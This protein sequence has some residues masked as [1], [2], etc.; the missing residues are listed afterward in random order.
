MYIY[1][2]TNNLFT[3][4]SGLDILSSSHLVGV[5][6]SDNAQIIVTKEMNGEIEVTVL[7][8][9][10]NTLA[11]HNKDE[12]IVTKKYPL[13]GAILR[14]VMLEY[15]GTRE[16]QES[17]GNGGTITVPVYPELTV[18][19][20]NPKF[21]GG[22]KEETITIKESL[23]WYGLPKG[24]RCMYLQFKITDALNVSSI[25]YTVT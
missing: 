18:I 3:T 14:R 22:K 2:I 15:S 1:D 12:C 4:Y 17:N 8:E 11:Q 6:Q 13:M 10:P 21:S 25:R 5:K 9:Y 23:V 24:L 19:C 7:K 20:Y 16:K